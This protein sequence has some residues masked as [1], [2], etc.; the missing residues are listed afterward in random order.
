MHEEVNHAPEPRIHYKVKTDGFSSENVRKAEF[1]NIRETT[2]RLGRLK[3]IALFYMGRPDSEPKLEP[4]SITIGTYPRSQF[5][6]FDFENPIE[7]WK[8]RAEDV[9]MLRAVLNDKFAES[10]SYVSD[11]SGAASTAI[12]AL[13]ASAL[14]SDRIAALL[15]ALAAS[16]EAQALFATEDAARLIAE[17]VTLERHRSA[18]EHLDRVARE[19][20]SVEGDL[21]RVLE[22]NWWMFGGRFV[23]LTPRRDYVVEDQMDIPLIRNDGSLHV[24]EL[25]K[26]N[27]PRIVTE[28][29]NHV[30]I[31]S[32]VN[33]AVG[34]TINYLRALDEQ[35]AQIKADFGVDTRRASA[36]VVIGHSSFVRDELRDAID[37][38]FRTYSA[39]VS[40]IEVISYDTLIAGARNALRFDS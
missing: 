5:G 9:R 4:T 26:A 36:T 18:V 31:G 12:Q 11:P 22:E 32:E 33:Q 2:G 40:R 14:P 20:T 39:Q 1:A 30:I 28:Y 8:G 10:G 3:Q 24:V 15:A 38:T 27:V 13:G 19:A 6:G 23:D 25:K 7:E 17:A 21:Q 35:R 29:R 37:E 16:P 34:Q